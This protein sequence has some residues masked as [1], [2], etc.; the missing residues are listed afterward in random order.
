MIG[1]RGT[2]DN[3]ESRERAARIFAHVASD[4]LVTHFPG[5]LQC[6][7]SLLESCE[8]KVACPSENPDEHTLTNK[9]DQHG[10]LE[11]SDHQ[12]D[13]SMIV[14]IQDQT[15]H[16]YE[17]V[18]SSFTW[19]D[20][21]LSPNPKERIKEGIKAARYRR[22]FFGPK[23]FHPYESRGAKEMICQGMLILERLTR[24]EENCTEITKHQLLL[25]RI[26]TQLRSHDFL[27][28]VQDATMDGMLSK[29]L[30]VMSRLLRSH[31]D[32]A[33]RLRQELASNTEAVSNLMG[34]LETNSEGAQ[35][36][37]E[38]A[39]EI[40]T[41]LTLASF[42]KPVFG[43]STFMLNKLCENLEIFLEEKVGET[44]AVEPAR[45]K[46]LRLSRL[47]AKAGDALQ[48]L[49]PFQSAS[50]VKAAAKISKQDAID[51]FTKVTR[52]QL[53]PPLHRFL[54]YSQF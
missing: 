48:R 49:L 51:K 9:N 11:K 18:A 7:C 30:T 24:D 54:S 33:T 19:L 26:T 42:T 45:E 22:R 2:G 34:I 14:P 46:A 15:G 50:I 23:Y 21:L 36:L 41:E 32:G 43:E 12:D 1:W 5:T 20:L 52:S 17:Q 37:H 4:L 35:Q 25:S 31:G 10:S 13:A 16:E 53:L 47:R 29:S 28:N 38:Q 8:P 3:I 39:V 40:L 44:I 27:S 6:I